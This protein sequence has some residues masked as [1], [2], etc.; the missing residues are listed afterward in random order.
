MA[1]P[2]GAAG[3]YQLLGE[4]ARGGMGIVLKARDGDLARDLAFKVLLD[5]HRDD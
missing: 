2:G 5:R 4:I 1:S 3:R